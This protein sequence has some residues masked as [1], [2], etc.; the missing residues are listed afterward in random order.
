M[1]KVL[2]LATKYIRVSRIDLFALVQAKD[3]EAVLLTDDKELRRAAENE[4]VRV[5][6]TLWVLDQMVER[7]LVNRAQAAKTLEQ[8]RVKN[9]YLPGAEVEKRLRQWKS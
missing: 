4:G 7:G 6:G 3:E 9:R 2:E 5:H 8:M 1:R